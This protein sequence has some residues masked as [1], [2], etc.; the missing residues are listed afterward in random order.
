MILSSL[1]L[2]RQAYDRD[3]SLNASMIQL[4]QL[5]RKHIFRIGSGV[6]WNNH[7]DKI[8]LTSIMC[9]QSHFLER[10]KTADGQEE[11]LPNDVVMHILEFVMD[12]ILSNVIVEGL[13]YATECAV[14]GHGDILS[15]QD[16]MK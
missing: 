16:K 2:M 3:I 4:V 1:W 6:V 14:V 8:T 13:R 11:K 9:F 7:F 15:T 5:T 12:D 10:I